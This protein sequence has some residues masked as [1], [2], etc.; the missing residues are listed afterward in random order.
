MKNIESVETESFNHDK[1]EKYCT[2]DK[3]FNKSS[4]EYVFELTRDLADPTKD[5]FPFLFY[6]SVDRYKFE[7]FLCFMNVEKAGEYLME[8]KLKDLNNEIQL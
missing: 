6:L 7:I 2:S 4:N 3:Y 1:I 8:K 5:Y